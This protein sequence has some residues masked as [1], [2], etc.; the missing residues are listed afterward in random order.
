MHTL[1]LVALLFG[2]P[3]EIAPPPRIAGG[4]LPPGTDPVLADWTPRPPRG[5]AEPWELMG[6]KE[7]ADPRFRLMNTGPALNCTMRF[8]A[9]RGTE[10]VY[11]AS[12]VKLGDAGGVVFD[13]ATMRL[14][15][16]WTGGYLNHSDRRFGLLNTPTPKG[17]M[18]LATPAGPGWA[19]PNGRGDLKGKAPTAPLP[20]EWEKYR[21]MYRSGNRVVYAYTVGKSEVLDSPWVETIGGVPCVVRTLRVGP[22]DKPETLAVG[23]LP[24]PA[25]STGQS[26]DVQSVDCN[27]DDSGFVIFAAKC[28]PLVA[29]LH[30]AGGGFVRLTF[31]PSK[32]P[33]VVRV[34]YANGAKINH[35]N[36]HD[37]LEDWGDPTDPTRWTKGGRDHWGEPLV[38]KL[39]RGTEDGPFAVDTLTLPYKNRFNALFFCTGLDFLPDGRVAVCT[40]HGDVWLATVDEKAAT[41]SWQR[42]ATGLYHPLGLKVVDGKVVVLERGQLTRLHDLN[43]DGEADFYEC[44]SNDWDTGAGEH[45][46]DTCLETDPDGNFYFFKTGDTDLPTGGCL[47]KV[48]KDGA[49]TEVFATGFRHPIGMGMSPTGL[50]TG[51]DQEGNWMPATR[52]DEYK[53]GGFYG[54]MRGHHRKVPPKRYDG[55]LC[56]LPRDVDNSAGGQ[57][58]VPKDTFGPLAGLPIHF[59]YGQCRPMVLLR[60]EFPDG[61]V[62]GGVAGLG[63]QF[64]SGVCR[65]RFHPTDGM[66][67]VC[68]LNGWQTAAKADGCVQRVRYTRKELDVPVKMA[69]D[70]NTIRLTF[71]REMDAQSCTGPEC[72]KAAWWNYRWEAAYGSKRWKVSDPNAEGQDEVPV[73]SAKVLDDGRT[74]ELRFEKLV[75]VMQM[76]VGYNVAAADGR[77]V[78]GSVFLTIHATK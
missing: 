14:A 22:C 74:V 7:W 16:G 18:L 13:R 60:Q 33:R 11:K 61:R 68:G 23:Q 3:P 52:V 66:M 37:A 41:V 43:A 17:E 27:R 62:Q 6:D 24:R 78:V 36:F 26:G 51:A 72:Y 54:D 63:V 30:D 9:P 73:K 56:W 25:V 75:P 67:Y 53:R 70:G 44:V 57:V 64:L 47:M 76:Q 29:K 32:T 48:S 21:G 39:V 38:T 8:P 50:L 77:K 2:Q 59:S 28:H 40:C 35:P 5:K 49:K 45:S 58:W 65:G 31:P 4:R 46:Y 1:T 34:V 20:P 71:S 55:P 69:V 19:D 10:T 12:A 15:A 42:F